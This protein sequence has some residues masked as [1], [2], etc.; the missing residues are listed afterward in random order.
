MPSSDSGPRADGQS[1]GE[2]A[3]IQAIAAKLGVAASASQRAGS[4]LALGVVIF[5][6]PSDALQSTNLGR[7][8]IRA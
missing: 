3:V 4:G 2:A 1:A 8:I 5:S 7:G 6:L